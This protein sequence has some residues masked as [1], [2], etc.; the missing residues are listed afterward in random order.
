MK[1]LLSTF[2]LLGGALMASAQET[3]MPLIQNVQA[4]E[5]MAQAA[6]HKLIRYTPRYDHEEL[7]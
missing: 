2:C 3:A 1:K 6:A 7:F 5:A 4:Y